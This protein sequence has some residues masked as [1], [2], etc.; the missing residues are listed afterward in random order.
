LSG[1]A[2]AEGGTTAFSYED[3][4][5]EPGWKS[6]SFR[7]P[8]RFNHFLEPIAVKL[9]GGIARVR[10]TPR[11]EHSNLRNTMH[12]GAMLGFMDIALFAA[13]RS[14][15]IIGSGGG[16]TVDLSAQFMGGPEV[17]VPIEARVELLRETGR[18][19]FLRGLV[20]QGEE[21]MASFA[22]TVRKATPRA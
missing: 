8:T 18:M 11:H 10:M 20:V 21:T 1:D 19:L 5:E 13:G 3:L 15:G 22:G 6:W 7:D 12:G 2:P 16:L 17:G 14:F 9:E 4:P